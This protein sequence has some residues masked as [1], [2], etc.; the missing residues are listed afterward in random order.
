MGWARDQRAESDEKS[1]VSPT[2]RLESSS[3]SMASNRL[4]P[5]VGRWRKKQMENAKNIPMKTPEQIEKIAE[6]WAF[7][8]A[9]DL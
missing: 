7:K 6:K 3:P 8:A 5:L 2:A 4:V 9:E 1:A